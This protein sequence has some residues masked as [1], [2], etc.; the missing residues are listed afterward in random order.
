VGWGGFG[1]PP[2]ERRN[3]K[4]ERFSRTLIDYRADVFR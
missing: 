2:R 1:H 3:G 4:V